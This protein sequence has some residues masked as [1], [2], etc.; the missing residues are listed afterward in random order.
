MDTKSLK[1]VGPSADGDRAVMQRSEVW[2]RVNYERA[3]SLLHLL[4]LLLP[5]NSD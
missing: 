2:D 3:S 5:N 4:P 1:G